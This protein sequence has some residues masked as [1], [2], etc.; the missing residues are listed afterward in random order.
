LALHYVTLVAVLATVLSF[1]FVHLTGWTTGDGVNRGS[2][3]TIDGDDTLRLHVDHDF[4]WLYIAVMSPAVLAIPWYGWL[5]WSWKGVAA[6][7]VPWLALVRYLVWRGLIY[8]ADSAVAIDRETLKVIERF[9]EATFYLKDIR[10]VSLRRVF[11]STYVCLTFDNLDS[12]LAHTFLVQKTSPTVMFSTLVRAFR[13][14][15]YTDAAPV[16]IRILK[17]DFS[18]TYVGRQTDLYKQGNEQYMKDLYR[19]TYKKHGFHCT[20]LPVFRD[21]SIVDL[22]REIDRRSQAAKNATLKGA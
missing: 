6:A 10:E 2:P 7:I 3:L 1:T 17:G 12:A 14:L 19:E 11:G 8:M 18:G 9:G 20:I 16:F 21:L 4:G 15:G 22:A 13:L 5:F